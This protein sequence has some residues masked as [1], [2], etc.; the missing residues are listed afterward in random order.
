M[1]LTK[2]F[3]TKIAG[4]T[5]SNTGTNTDSRQRII[6]ELEMTGKLDRGQELRLARKP[7]NPYDDHAVAVFGPDGRQ[8]G[9][10]AREVARTVFE[11][12]CCG[13]IYRIFVSEVTGGGAGMSY[14]VNVKIDC[15]AS[16]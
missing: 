4:V 15:Y 8:L 14:G 5:F 1:R 13:N 7:Q 11:G 6:H 2:T 12:M 16:R 3:Y 10:L 9:Y